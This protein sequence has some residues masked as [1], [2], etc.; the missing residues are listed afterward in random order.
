M[1]TRRREIRKDLL[2]AL[3]GASHSPDPDR[4]GNGLGDAGSGRPRDGSSKGST[5]PPA[6]TEKV[7]LR[8]ALRPRNRAAERAA[9]SRQDDEDLAAQ[10]RA[11]DGRSDGHSN[12]PARGG[13]RSLLDAMRQR[14]G[15]AESPRRDGTTLRLGAEHTTTSGEREQYPFPSIAR[16]SREGARRSSRSGN[17]RSLLH[18]LRPGTRADDGDAD[19]ATESGNG[20]A[21]LEGLRTRARAL[22]HGLRAPEA[23]DG[24]R[25]DGDGTGTLT[26]PRRGGISPPW[27][28]SPKLPPPPGPRPPRGGRPRL[29][30]LR[31]ALVVMG[32]GLLALVSW[33]FGVM[34]SVSQD[35]PALENREQYKHARNSVVLDR[36]GDRLATLTGNERRLLVSSG[37][38]SQTV[39]QSVV[40][41]E[42]Q[43]FYEHRGVDF[44]GI[45]RAV[46]QDVLQQQ[47]VQGASTIT[48]QF[49][50]NALR[51]Q[52]SRTVFQKLR[53]SALAYHLERRWSKDKI[54]T[55][56]LNS[57]YFGEGAYGIEAAAQTYFGWNHSGCGD[58]GNRCASQLLP[59][60][61]AL[62]AGM[63]SSPSAYS[64]RAN[65]EA[66]TDRRNLVLEKMV[67]QGVLAPEAAQESAAAKVPNASQID[68][69]SEDSL[70]PYFTTWLRQ[71]VVDRYGA[72][73]AFG[74]GLQIQSTFDLE[75]QQAVEEIASGTLAG[76]GPTASIAV[77]DNRTGGVLAMVGGNDYEKEPFN[78][79]TNGHRQ[80]GSAFKPFT[81]V[82]ALEEGH[83]PDEVFT[84][85]EKQLRFT[86]PGYKKPHLF[87][88]KNYEDTYYGSQ[89]IAGATTTSDNSV[90]AELGL[91]VGPGD[92]A[93]TAEK[94]GIQTDVSTN[95]AM[96]LGGL[97]T[98]VSPLEMAY[99]YSTLGRSGQRIGG[100]MDS[101]P[102]SAL[103]PVAI[104]KVT[105][106]DGEPVEDK[107]GSS[108]ENDV[109]TEQVL[110]PTASDTAV[111]LLESVVSSG[112][113]R[114]AA[115]GDFAWGKTGTT[116]DNGDAWFVGGTKDITAA[117]WVGH[118]DSNTPMETEYSGGPVDGGTY[119]A[120]IWHDLVI[121]YQSIIGSPRQEDR[122]RNAERD[123]TTVPAAP[124]APAPVAPAPVA[125]APV[126]PT[127]PE[128]EP[129]APPDDAAPAP[130][131]PPSGGGTGATGAS[132]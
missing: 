7:S 1:A 27:H 112:T 43:R 11:R 5:R 67:E 73:E 121:A 31:L 85:Q 3:R 86:V 56:Y 17:G 81:L 126:A 26:R 18:A 19:E 89:S 72:G 110:D 100:T 90:Y 33:F 61:A 93:K 55:E 37:E 15:A 23:P 9:R 123:A 36:D 6:R 74:G 47:A 78:L 88:V 83:S 35:L 64:P 63:I 49:V 2:D 24:L 48:Q 10:T 129:A 111:G 58:E 52:S 46:V 97:E 127:E 116:D 99:A 107:T 87:E 42:D 103:G 34:M 106:P 94:M 29:K 95:P 13:G 4:R 54:L 124:V 16:S 40:A 131:T 117:V 41:V 92:V 77:I 82:R 45:G 104:S 125:P 59:E 105:D 130:A 114:S 70:S 30:K 75:Y 128:P 79:A 51:A 60:E 98:G 20:A 39:K 132:R 118:A 109:Q 108:G 113:G 21:T 69:H 96:L 80:P 101:V 84:S 76:I 62:L 32:L 14:D 91:Q 102:G 66:A 68:P 22:L 65:P 8:D 12:R 122:E 28:R 120:D 38:I 71:Q 119:P 57:I 115:T 44:Q 50:K 53:E 25:E